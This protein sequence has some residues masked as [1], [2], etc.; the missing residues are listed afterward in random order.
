MLAQFLTYVKNRKKFLIIPV[1][2][3]L[4]ILLIAIYLNLTSPMDTSFIYTNV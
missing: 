2:V 3:V 1:L 4:L